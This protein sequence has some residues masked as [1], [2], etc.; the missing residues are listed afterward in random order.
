M[1]VEIKTIPLMSLT[2][3]FFIK[4]KLSS[5][6]EELDLF[7]NP[8]L[9]VHEPYSREVSF[10]GVVTKTSW[11]RDFGIQSIPVN[12]DVVMLFKLTYD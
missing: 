4:E 10:G 5:S 6:C 9:L 12:S 3:L 8:K 7:L 11:E 2:Y 1:Y